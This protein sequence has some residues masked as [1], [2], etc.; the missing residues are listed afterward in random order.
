MKP[1][2]AI[3]AL[4][5]V[6]G[7]CSRDADAQVRKRLPGTWVL[8]GTHR[9]GSTFTST[10]AVSKAGNYVCRIVSHGE[11]GSERS[12]DLK[13]MFRVQGGVLIDTITNHSNTNAV[14]PMIMRARIVHFDDR[15][16]VLESEP[17]QEVE[18]PTNQVV[19]R[20]VSQ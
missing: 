18:F 1:S 6:L 17:N 8:T 14:L 5:F 10:I 13:G 15:E 2:L 12:F 16:M 4:A 9:N 19:F 7:G 20:K 3:A 11:S